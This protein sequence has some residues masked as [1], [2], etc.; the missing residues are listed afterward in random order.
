[1]ASKLH[2]FGW[3]YGRHVAIDTAAA[4]NQPGMSLYIGMTGET[5]LVVELRIAVNGRLMGIVACQ[6]GERAVAVAEAGG[7]MQV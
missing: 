7:A 4:A 1:M 3:A 6:A 2:V 5:L